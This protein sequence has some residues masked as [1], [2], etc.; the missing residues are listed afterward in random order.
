MQDFSSRITSLSSYVC[1]VCLS[2]ADLCSSF[3]TFSYIFKLVS[4]VFIIFRYVFKTCFHELS[5]FIFTLCSSSRLILSHLKSLPQHRR[6]QSLGKRKGQRSKRDKHG[7][8]QKS[9]PNPGNS[10]TQMPGDMPS[11]TGNVWHDF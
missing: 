11:N 6:F 7:Q 3:R 2:S 4:S 5:V 10:A 1:F 9:I 8:T